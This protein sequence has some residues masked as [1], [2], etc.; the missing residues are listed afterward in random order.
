MGLTINGLYLLVF[1][2][3][4]LARPS[5]H[6]YVVFAIAQ[7]VTIGVA[8]P[9]Y[10]TWVFASR[11]RLRGDLTR[12]SGVWWVTMIGSALSLPLLVDV[13]GLRPLAAQVLAIAALALAN[14]LGH[15]FVS[16]RHVHD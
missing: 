8:F 9:L 7:A 11:G 15:R 5:W 10:R 14:Y 6:Y 2:G 4:A 13:F 16:F 1:A 12:F 3:V